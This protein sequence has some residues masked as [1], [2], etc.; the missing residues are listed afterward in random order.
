VIE[1]NT[2]DAVHVLERQM[3]SVYRRV[4]IGKPDPSAMLLKVD[5]PLQL[6]RKSAAGIQMI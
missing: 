2:V 1:K 5:I 4:H 3:W 6:N